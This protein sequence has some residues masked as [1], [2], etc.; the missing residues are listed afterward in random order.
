[1][2]LNGNLFRSIGQ[3]HFDEISLANMDVANEAASAKL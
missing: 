2:P 3:T 1:M